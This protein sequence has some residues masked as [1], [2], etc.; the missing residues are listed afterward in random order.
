MKNYNNNNNISIII[1]IPLKMSTTALPHGGISS[2]KDF[3]Y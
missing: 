1:M 3:E 2:I